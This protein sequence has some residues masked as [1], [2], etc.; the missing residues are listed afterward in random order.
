M[1]R[2]SSSSPRRDVSAPQDDEIELIASQMEWHNDQ[3]GNEHSDNC[4]QSGDEQGPVEGEGAWQGNLWVDPVDPHP[5][6]QRERHLEEAIDPDYEPEQRQEAPTGRSKHRRLRPSPTE[7]D[8]ES[9]GPDP[10]TSDS[11]KKGDEVNEE[12][13]STLKGNSPLM[14]SVQQES[15]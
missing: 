11:Q 14:Q 7:E 8:N 3:S 6:A 9:S 12:E 10:T 13:T 5:V 2:P 15:P 1:D 4:E